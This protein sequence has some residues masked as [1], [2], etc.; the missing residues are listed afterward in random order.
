MLLFVRVEYRFYRF[1]VVVI[2]WG[3]S[4]RLLAVIKPKYATDK[5]FYKTR[6]I[7]GKILDLYRCLG[8]ADDLQQQ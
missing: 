1:L 5:F 8:Y 2:L 3:S 6:F 7:T 4:T